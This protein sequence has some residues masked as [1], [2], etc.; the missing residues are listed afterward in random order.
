MPSTLDIVV[1]AAARM[2]LGSCWNILDESTGGDEATVGEEVRAGDI[3]EDTELVVRER[4]CCGDRLVLGLR[5]LLPPGPA[6]EIF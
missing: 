1:T 5:L 3:S 6:L 2:F 4:V